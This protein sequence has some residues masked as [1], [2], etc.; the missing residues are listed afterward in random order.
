MPKLQCKSCGKVHNFMD[1]VDRYVCDCDAVNEVDPKVAAEIA[2]KKAEAEVKAAEEA[3]A[4]AEAAK[5]KVAEAQAKVKEAEAKAN[6]V[7]STPATQDAEIAKTEA[8]KTEK[9]EDDKKPLDFDHLK[10]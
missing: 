10:K 3:V 6:A 4:K 1:Q 2:A 9:A 7:P 8:V 5:A